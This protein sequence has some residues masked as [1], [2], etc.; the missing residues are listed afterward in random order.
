MGTLYREGGTVRLPED[1][2]STLSV[3]QSCYIFFSPAIRV[4]NTTRLLIP[5]PSLDADAMGSDGAADPAGPKPS[6]SA[7]RFPKLWSKAIMDVFT[8]MGDH[9]IPQYSL[10]ARFKQVH[11]SAVKAF[12]GEFHPDLDNELWSNLK[13]FVT[14]APFEFDPVSTIV[15][16]DPQ[17][18]KARAP[19]KQRVSDDGDEETAMV[20]ETAVPEQPDAAVLVD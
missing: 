4:H 2:V 15:R 1:S 18:V 8:S 3:G 6:V 11:S 16:F 20:E 12:F 7:K 9:E 14:K 19:K 17:A 5:Q 10:I 13:R